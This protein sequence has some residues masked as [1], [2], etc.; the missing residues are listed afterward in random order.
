MYAFNPMHISYA[1][2]SE[3]KEGREIQICKNRLM[4][5]LCICKTCSVILDMLKALNK[6]DQQGYQILMN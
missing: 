5:K 4:Q 2:K 3:G 1:T 6:T